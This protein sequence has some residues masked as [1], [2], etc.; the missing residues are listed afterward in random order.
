MDAM[1]SDEHEEVLA[2]RVKGEVTVEPLAGL[3]T[4]G[5]AK[6]VAARSGRERERSANLQIFMEA[7]HLSEV[8]FGLTGLQLT[9]GAEPRAAGSLDRAEAH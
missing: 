3:A 4:V 2:A 5:L 6:A 1:G 8:N 9:P 7:R